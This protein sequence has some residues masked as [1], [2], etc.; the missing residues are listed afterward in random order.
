MCGKDKKWRYEL[1]EGRISRKKL[2]ELRSVSEELDEFQEIFEHNHN[3]TLTGSEQA[4]YDA[5]EYYDRTLQ[6]FFDAP[7]TYSDYP[8]LRNIIVKSNEMNNGD[9][10]E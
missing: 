1:P 4:Q 2:N 8:G 7:E 6:N 9:I 3:Y 5:L 10:A